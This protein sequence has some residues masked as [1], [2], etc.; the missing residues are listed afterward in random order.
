MPSGRR[1]PGRRP[2]RRP[3]SSSGARRVADAAR[4]GEQG[5]VVGVE[6]VAGGHQRERLV[7]GLSASTLRNSRNSR[8]AAAGCRRRSRPARRPCRGLPPVARRRLGRL[9]RRPSACWP[10]GSWSLGSLR[11][12]SSSSPQPASTT[13][14]AASRAARRVRVRAVMGPSSAGTRVTRGI[15]GRRWSACRS[16]GRGLR[17]RTGRRSWP[18]RCSCRAPG[19]DT[20]IGPVSHGV[21]WSSI[22]PWPIPRSTIVAGGVPEAAHGTVPSKELAAPSALNVP[23]TTRPSAGSLM[24]TG[25]STSSWAARSSGSLVGTPSTWSTGLPSR[26]TAPAAARWPRPAACRRPAARRA[27]PSRRSCRRDG[28]A[29]RHRRGSRR[30]ADVCAHDDLPNEPAGHGVGS[31]GRRAAVDV[32]RRRSRSSPGGVDLVELAEQARPVRRRR[33]V[34][35]RAARWTGAWPSRWRSGASP[36]PVPGRWTAGRR[37]R[38]R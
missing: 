26:R 37:S 24:L 15:Y 23:S 36:G 21:R 28:R 3:R 17:R 29:A 12:G 34:V 5:A 9:L 19:P 38:C 13:T 18:R 6:R 10:G 2:E 7:G 11:G 4:P 35:D 27:R 14:E 32:Q 31:R 25:A 30:S 33:R 20:S 1:G 8:G 16:S 22:V